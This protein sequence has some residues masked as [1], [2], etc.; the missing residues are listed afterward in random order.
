VLRLL[1]IGRSNARDAAAAAAGKVRNNTARAAGVSAHVQIVEI[2]SMALAR[3]LFTAAG[4]ICY[5][6]QLGVT[7]LNATLPFARSHTVSWHDWHVPQWLC[8]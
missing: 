6:Q 5:H 7:D 1:D 2:A 3:E 4:H 8:M